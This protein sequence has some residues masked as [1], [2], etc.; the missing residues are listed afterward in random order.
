VTV[1]SYG[2]GIHAIA[3]VQYPRYRGPNGSEA[4][5]K[6]R[7][8]GRYQS[9]M[10]QINGT[11]REKLG[12]SCLQYNRVASPWSRK[13]CVVIARCRGFVSSRH[14]VTEWIVP[15]K[16]RARARARALSL[17]TYFEQTLGGH[18]TRRGVGCPRVPFG[19]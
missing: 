18:P 14:T 9:G 12:Q 8:L 15:N 16:A 1:V 13:S 4:F 19:S 17:S 6:G 2:I 7:I 5:D 10:D 11:A 3:K